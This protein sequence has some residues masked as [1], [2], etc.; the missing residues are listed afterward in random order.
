MVSLT[1]RNGGVKTSIIH[2]SSEID[3]FVKNVVT[4]EKDFFE[5]MGRIG[6]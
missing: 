2:P 4:E 3:E 5:E 1:V 6:D